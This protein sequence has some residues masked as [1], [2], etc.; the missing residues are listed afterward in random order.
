[1]AGIKNK[2]LILGSIIALLAIVGA[3][4]FRT[5]GFS[6]KD[7]ISALPDNDE[8]TKLEFITPEGPFIFERVDQKWQTEFEETVDEKK[9]INLLKLLSLLEIHSP[10]PESKSGKY[11]ALFES[12]SKTIKAYS[13][14]KQVYTLQVINHQQEDLGLSGSQKV[15]FLNLKGH[16]ETSLYEAIPN[17]ASNFFDNILI[18]LSSEQVS[19][20]QVEYPK[21]P[22]N[23]YT[24]MY[25]DQNIALFDNNKKEISNFDTTALTD[26]KH[27]FSGIRYEQIDTL[28][29]SPNMNEHLFRLKLATTLEK[30]WHIDAYILQN[31]ITGKPNTNEFA[32][33]VNNK[34][35]VKL[36]YAD[37][38]PV[39]LDL[40]YF[41]RN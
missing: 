25:Q 30:I 2:I 18:N 4:K 11:L 7:Q 40:D 20:V 21:S 33:I 27:F 24:V 29:F 34:I 5:T 32:A 14:N 36:K 31:K 8:I 22:E 23:G 1:M 26:Y 28:S 12:Q 3:L 13:N 39:L 9:I 17:T 10:V 37:F 19:A 35:M 6:K 15:F 16:S 38:D 41:S